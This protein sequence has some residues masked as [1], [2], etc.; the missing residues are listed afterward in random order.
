MSWTRAQVSFVLPPEMHIWTHKSNSSVFEELCYKIQ[1]SFLV[2]VNSW[3]IK[4]QIIKEKIREVAPTP[5]VIVCY[6]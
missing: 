6:D 4:F 5:I 1:V 3:L 2:D